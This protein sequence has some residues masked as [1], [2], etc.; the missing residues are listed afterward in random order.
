MPSWRRNIC[1]ISLLSV[2][3]CARV[4]VCVCACVRVS[5]GCVSVWSLSYK[6]K[7]VTSFFRDVGRPLWREVRSVVFSSCWASPLQPFTDLSP[8]GVMSIFYCLYFWDL[9]FTCRLK[10]FRPTRTWLW[11]WAR[12][13]CSWGYGWGH[14]TWKR[15]K[16]IV[17]QRKLKS[18][19]VP[20]RGPGTKTNWPTDRR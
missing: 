20:H 18:D 10:K 14:P 12:P 9:S 6:R 17:K 5:G 4:C 2:C 15:K 13:P 19:H 1:Y 8:T 7:Q 3:A 11:L 16:V